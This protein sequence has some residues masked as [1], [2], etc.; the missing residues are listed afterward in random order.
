VYLDYA[1][2]MSAPDGS[3]KPELTDDGLHPNPAGYAV[4]GPLVEAA[5]Q[6]ALGMRQAPPRTPPA[7]PGR[8]P[9]TPPV[10]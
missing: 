9:P 3:L 4:M 2:P 8:T 5:I 7:P 6:K 1:T 10:P